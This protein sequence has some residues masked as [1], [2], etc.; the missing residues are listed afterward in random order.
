MKKFIAA[1]VLFLTVSAS[2]GNNRVDTLT[3]AVYPN[4]PDAGY[5]REIIEQRW[6]EVEPEIRLVRAEWNCYHDG[7]PDGIDVIMYDAVVRDDLIENGWIQPIA[8]DAVRESEDIFPF[9]LEG[10]TADGRLYGIPVFLCGNFLI[11]DVGCTDLAEA[12]HLTDL[13]D[14]SGILVISSER[15]KNRVQYIYEVLADTLGEANPTAGEDTDGLMELIDRLA[16]DA[17]K[18]DNSTQVALAYD[19]GIGKGYIGFSESLHLLNNRISR[20][21]IRSI[22]FSDQ[23]NVARFYVDAV[24]VNSNVKGARYEK[25]IE[26]MNVIAEADVLSSLSVQNGAAQYLLPARKTPYET[27]S[28]RFPLYAELEKL[29]SDDS[30]CVILGPRP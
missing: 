6:A 22:S 29:A 14:E 7:V 2:Y 11:Y 23:D 21:G 10:L 27:L 8:R 16:V 19:S 1:I 9:A 24:A 12:E 17:H 3:Y 18:R 20:T 5:Y 13:G 30:N 4:I 26:L 15:D 25:C 28:E